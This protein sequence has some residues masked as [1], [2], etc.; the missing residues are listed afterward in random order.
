MQGD[1]KEIKM[2]KKNTLL[3]KFEEIIEAEEEMDGKKEREEDQ[4]KLTSLALEISLLPVK[5]KKKFIEVLFKNISDKE[6]QKL[7]ETIFRIINPEKYTKISFKLEKM[8]E[9]NEDLK[10]YLAARIIRNYT[11]IPLKMLPFLT[12]MAQKAKDRVRKRQKKM[13]KEKND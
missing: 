4:D 11:N 8:F 7:M 12:K 1:K 3:D 6:R 9:K 5:E 13:K 10:P 2:S